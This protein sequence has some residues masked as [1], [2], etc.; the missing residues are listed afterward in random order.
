MS[1]FNRITALRDRLN[2]DGM[3]ITGFLGLLVIFY[4]ELF[5]A[6]S[7]SLMG[8]HWEQHYP[9]AFFMAQSL[10]QGVWQF[11]TP[12]IQ[13]G[14]PIAAESQI[15]LF[16]IPNIFLYLALPF[17]WAYSYMNLIHFFIGGISAYAYCRKVGL[18]PMGA[19]IAAI[20]FVF[21]AGYGGAYYNITSLKT[22]TWFPWILLE[23][24][25]YCTNFRKRHI[26]ATALLMA[27]SIMAG[28]LQIAVLMMFICGLY[29][30]LRIFCFPEDSWNWIVKFRIAGGLSVAGAFAVLFSAPQLYLTFELAKFSNRIGLSEGYAYVGSLP[31]PALLTIIF[32]HLQ[33]FFRGSCLY[34]GIFSIVFITAAFFVS[35]RSLR[36]F[37]WLW[38]ALAILALLL[39][40]GQWSPFYVG[41]IKMTHFYSFRIPAKFLI[42]FC[43]SAAMLS[44]LGVHALFS[45]LAN[46]SRTK[47]LFIS[48]CFVV[49]SVIGAIWGIVYFFLTWGY[50]WSLKLGKLIV[51]SYIYGKPGHPRSWESYVEHVHS[52]LNG[53][54]TALS[55]T[56]PWLLW[57]FV[58][59]FSVGL[60]LLFFKRNIRLSILFPLAMMILLVDFYV[61]A[62]ADIKKDFDTYQ[63]VLKP[64]VIIQTL[65]A[66]KKMG[67]LG[68]VYGFRKEGEK[69]PLKPSVNMLYEIEDIG[70]YSPLI[71]G[72]YFETMGQLGNVNDS[73][74]MMEPEPDFVLNRLPLLDSLDVSHIL[75]E[76]KLSHPDLEMLISD[77]V[78][79]TYLYRSRREHRRGYF[80]SENVSFVDWEILKQMLMAPGFNPQKSLLLENAE[81]EK[82]PKDFSLDINSRAL[83][84]SQKTYSPASEEWIVE[85]TGSGFFVMTNTFYPG[86]KARLN[87]DSVPLLRAYGLFYSVYIPG[88]GVYRIALIYKPFDFRNRLS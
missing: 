85:T 19:F 6:K 75:A 86:W 8:D 46:K 71:I 37:F 44:G 18:I 57:T 69:L 63:N 61:L 87:G 74:R 54:G 12:L 88:P 79:K 48:A 60:W 40:L 31:P 62:W 16:Y 25:N 51:T 43:F 45:D 14:F 26:Y 3:A 9:W 73:N 4:P 83:E 76:R 32:P 42:F 77:P 65:L 23:F 20:I 33:G 70:G 67:R 72:R 64:N 41:L 66:E 80:I 13:C 84:I 78:S 15:G 59:M 22:L 56:Q 53:A 28:Y 21:G 82:L 11:W 5:L 34:S 52:L 49:L 17:E 81:K 29:F 24:E 36:K 30:F 1:A 35:S 50:A 2:P 58:L 47:R 39:A 55:L 7:A 38:M 10:K 27:L 68:R